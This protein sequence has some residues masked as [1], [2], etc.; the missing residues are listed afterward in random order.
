MTGEEATRAMYGPGVAV[1][2]RLVDGQRRGVAVVGSIGW[3]WLSVGRTI[4]GVSLSFSVTLHLDD[5]FVCAMSL[6]VHIGRGR[7][8]SREMSG[9]DRF[10]GSQE[11]G[12]GK[13]VVVTVQRLLNQRSLKEVSKSHQE[14]KGRW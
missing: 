6:V 3:V 4:G 2:N 7:L 12:S 9:H 11:C 1:R 8:D 14:P 10:R 5:V 13:G